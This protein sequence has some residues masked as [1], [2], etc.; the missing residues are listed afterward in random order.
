[1]YI[2]KSAIIYLYA[3]IKLL[4]FNSG[5]FTNIFEVRNTIIFIY[6]F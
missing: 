1:M 6:I 5:E 2:F 4:T 3:V